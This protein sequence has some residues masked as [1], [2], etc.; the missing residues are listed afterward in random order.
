MAYR[1]VVFSAFYF[2]RNTET[3]YL[4]ANDVTVLLLKS[5]DRQFTFEISLV[6][7][8]LLLRNTY[9]MY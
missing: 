8:P 3:E 2:I 9:C 5:E 6:L 4:K 7:F 1:R